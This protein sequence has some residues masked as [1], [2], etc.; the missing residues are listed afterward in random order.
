[1]MSSEFQK[2]IYS[3]VEDGGVQ[4]G[5]AE[6]KVGTVCYRWCVLRDFQC[7]MSGFESGSLTPSVTSFF[8][9]FFISE[10]LGDE[11]WK[12]MYT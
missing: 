11:T 7:T 4:V 12:N 1:M 6:T 2:S 9:R 10:G 5:G 8:L 3:S